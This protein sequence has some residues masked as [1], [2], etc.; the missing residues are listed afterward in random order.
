MGKSAWLVCDLAPMREPRLVLPDGR[1][2]LTVAVLEM[3]AL[4][5]ATVES[6]QPISKRSLSVQLP[7]R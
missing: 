1:I 4:E 7:D 5:A 2:F 3:P 6:L